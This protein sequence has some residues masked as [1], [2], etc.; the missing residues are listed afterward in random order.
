MSPKQ[1]LGKVK[2]I[3]H[4]LDIFSFGWITL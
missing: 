2:E 3:D 1:A 4:R